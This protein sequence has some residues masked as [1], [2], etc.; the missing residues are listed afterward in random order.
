MVHWVIFCLGFWTVWAGRRT[1]AAEGIHP[2]L[3]TRCDAS[4]SCH[5]SFSTIVDCVPSDCEPEQTPFSCNLI[6]LGSLSQQE[7]KKLRHHLFFVALEF[8][9]HFRRQEKVLLQ[10]PYIVLVMTSVATKCVCHFFL[11]TWQD[12]EGH[13]TDFTFNFSA[14]LDCITHN[15]L[16]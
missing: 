14:S 12:G 15:P 5:L 16:C 1:W 4:S 8:R 9:H 2:S 7:E 3:P 10:M 11:I 6:F 13:T